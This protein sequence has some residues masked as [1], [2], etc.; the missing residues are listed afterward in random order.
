[1]DP[2]DVGA[3]GHRALSW[4]TA[5]PAVL[6]LAGGLL[7]GYFVIPQ[8]SDSKPP[9]KSEIMSSG[10]LTCQLTHQFSVPFDPDADFISDELGPHRMAALGDLAQSVSPDD[11]RFSGIAEIGRDLILSVQDGDLDAVGA[12]IGDIRELCGLDS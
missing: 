5:V 2:N 11:E 3:K 10:E 4:W 8:P 9:N 1:M 7:L 12:H 6:A